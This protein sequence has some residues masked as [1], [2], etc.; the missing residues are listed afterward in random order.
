MYNITKDFIYNRNIKLLAIINSSWSYS[1]IY[2]KISIFCF[3]T[4]WNDYFIISMYANIS[5]NHAAFLLTLFIEE[6]QIDMQLK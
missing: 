1:W 5:P 6:I 3:S 2:H 4:L